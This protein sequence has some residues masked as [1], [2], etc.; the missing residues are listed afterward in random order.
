MSASDPWKYGI[1][2]IT[3]IRYLNEGI[4][5]DRNVGKCPELLK[6]YHVLTFLGPIGPSGHPGRTGDRG[7]PGREGE[8]QNLLLISTVLIDT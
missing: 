7:D 4:W 5:I 1:R 2:H 6:Y 3:L 8:I